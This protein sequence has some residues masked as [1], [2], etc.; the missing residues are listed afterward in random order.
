MSKKSLRLVADEFDGFK[1]GERYMYKKGDLVKLTDSQVTAFADKFEDPRVQDELVE[2]AARDKVRRD[3]QEAEDAEAAA[4]QQKKIETEA[5]RQREA[6]KLLAKIEAL[7]DVD[8]A[9]A[10][11]TEKDED[12]RKLLQA[13]STLRKAAK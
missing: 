9:K 11:Q 12:V 3:K 1:S 6:E 8:L 13:E 5:A 4:E 2:K 10:L 7:S